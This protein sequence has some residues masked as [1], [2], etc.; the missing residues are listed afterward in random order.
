MNVISYCHVSGASINLSE[1]EVKEGFRFHNR[2][3]IKLSNG[4]AIESIQVKFQC[5]IPAT[6]AAVRISSGSLN[7]YECGV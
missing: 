7:Y 5:T 1:I 6:E 2:S 3:L 4:A